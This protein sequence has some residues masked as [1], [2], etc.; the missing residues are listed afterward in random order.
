MARKIDTEKLL[1]ERFAKMDQHLDSL[2]P[3]SE[4]YGRLLHNLCE[5]QSELTQFK[6]A[7][8]TA[9]DNEIKREEQRRMNDEE[10][11]YKE[12]QLEHEETRIVYD[13]EIRKKQG[14]TNLFIDLGRLALAGIGEAAYEGRWKRAMDMEYNASD[15]TNV[16]PPSSINR[17]LTEKKP[18]INNF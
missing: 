4:E 12:R 15:H 17:L 1:K 7:V 10:L 9:V 2:E 13:Y 14:R 8:D 16:I 6:K 5:V 3:G 18:K 11:K